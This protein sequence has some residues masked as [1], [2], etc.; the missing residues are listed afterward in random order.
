MKQLT[1]NSL[2][3]LDQF[4][5]EYDSTKTIV[6]LFTGTKT[7]NGKSWCP[8][9]V[10]ADPI[11]ESVVD[12]LKSDDGIVFI[13]VPVGDLPTWKSASNQYRSHAQYKVSCVPTM[14]NLK[15]GQRLE[16]G[17]C[18][19]EN[20]VKQLF[21][22]TLESATMSKAGTCEGGVCRIR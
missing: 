11:V 9:C 21:Q 2:L 3:E 16:E 20:M 1:A 14:I 5:K 19:D 18:A 7:E 8:D 6:L 4:V 13:T 22:G 12:Q 17:G 10:V 15:K